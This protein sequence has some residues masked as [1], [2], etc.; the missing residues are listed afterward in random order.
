MK[1]AAMR[2]RQPPIR[3]D[4]HPAWCGCTACIGPNRPTTGIGHARRQHRLPIA[5]VGIATAI[6]GAI[7]LAQF[8]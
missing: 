7:A 2:G 5:F 1:R 6:L 8:I 3:S 4:I